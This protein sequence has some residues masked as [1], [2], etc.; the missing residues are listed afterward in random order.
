MSVVLWWLAETSKR[1]E[2]GDVEM[3]HDHGHLHHPGDENSKPLANVNT[4]RRQAEMMGSWGDDEVIL[5][6]VKFK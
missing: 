5:R 1:N 6:K 3:G 2:C 4:G